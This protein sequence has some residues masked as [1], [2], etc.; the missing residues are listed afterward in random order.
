VNDDDERARLR[1]QLRAMAAVNHHLRV[2]LD[3]LQSAGAAGATPADRTPPTAARPALHASERRSRIASEWLPDLV[4]A[5]PA[6]RTADPSI[7]TRADRSLYLVEGTTR[8]RLAVVLLAP[9]LEQ[10]Y[11]ERRPIDDAAFHALA[12]GAPVEVLEGP[13]GPPFVI[14]GG[15]RLALRGLGLTHGVDQATVDALP[16]GPLLDVAAATVA[17]RAIVAA[18]WVGPLAA[19]TPDAGAHLATAPDGSILVVEGGVGRPVRAGLLVPALETAL[20]ERRP[21]SA[22]D[23][24]ALAEGPPVELIEGRSGLPFVVVGG[25]RLPVAGLPLPHPV[26]RSPLDGLP[27]GPALDA[28]SAIRSRRA[29]VAGAWLAA[30]GTEAAAAGPPALVSRPDGS[31]Y[32]VEGDHRRH[33]TS[34]LLVPS[35]EQRL[36]SRR[37]AT[38]EEF[39]GWTEGAPVEVLEG[40]TGAPFL[41]IGAVRIP[42]RN[43]PLPHPIRASSLDGLPEGPPI[44]LAAVQRAAIKAVE[45]AQVDQ[46]EREAKPDPT[47]ELKALVDQKGVMRAAAHIIKRKP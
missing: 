3:A 46:A 8:R 42:V 44:D 43:L 22:D 40:P 14:V 41:V 35:L 45:T 21:M 7:V 32:V 15:R 37:P 23:V 12:E 39:A 4:D 9:A 16:E 1:R 29:G 31:L 19:T 6:A 25:R 24:A 26:E 30:L 18:D 11:G 33:I 34:G 10:L 20:G 5:A 13:T 2:Q 27:E 36:G 47:G 17:R 38:D 28:P